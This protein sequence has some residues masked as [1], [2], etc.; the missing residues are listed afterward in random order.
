MTGGGG[1]DLQLGGYG[2][3]SQGRGGGLIMPKGENL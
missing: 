1:G 2:A 3:H